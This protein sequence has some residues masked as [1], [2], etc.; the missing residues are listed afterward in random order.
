M[1]H[2]GQKFLWIG[3]AIAIGLGLLWQFYPLRDAQ[4]RIKALPQNGLS[5]SGQDLQ[6]PDAMRALFG[7]AEVIKRGYQVGEQ[8]FIV[9]I[10][11]GSHNRHAVHDPLYCIR[12]DGWTV[13]SQN[14]FPVDGGTAQLIRAEKKGRET[15]SLVWFS[16]GSE[17]HGS[18]LRYWWQTTLRRLTLGHAGE[19][20]ILVTVQPAGGAPVNWREL[21][22][23]FPALFEL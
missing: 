22:E 3:L 1:T 14:D 9:W 7:K 18:A 17:R 11:D 10:I 5:Y 23:K 20:P 2:R 16:N 6:I 8:R 21:T 13:I 12:G 19:E 4:A 15:E